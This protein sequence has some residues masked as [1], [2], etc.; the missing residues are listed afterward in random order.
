MIF[1]LG[2]GFELDQYLPSERH[3]EKVKESKCRELLADIFR[4][5]QDMKED[6][7]VTYKTGLERVMIS[8]VT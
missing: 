1:E 3:Y 8:V 6:E 2:S 7:S 5:V 4:I